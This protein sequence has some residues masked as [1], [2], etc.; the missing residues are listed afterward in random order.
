MGGDE[1]PIG[2]DE[3]LQ[4][5]NDL[6]LWGIE[7]RMGGDE[8]LQW[9][10][11]LLLWGNE[12]RMGGDESLQWADESLLWGVNAGWG[13]RELI[14]KGSK[15]F[16]RGRCS[17]APWFTAAQLFGH[18]TGSHIPRKPI[19]SGPGWAVLGEWMSYSEEWMPSWLRL[20]HWKKT[21]I[22]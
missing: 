11:D 18:R 15:M 17:C 21:R 13:S 19:L 1:S 14:L 10:N 2:G 8:S 12:S 5:G 22:A 3:S 16:A 20:R 9:G 6:L 7:C 4:W